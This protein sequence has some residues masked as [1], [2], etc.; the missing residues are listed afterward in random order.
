M[1][2]LHKSVSLILVLLMLL[3]CLPVFSASAADADMRYGRKKLGEAANGAAL[4]YVYDQL[5]EGC[6]A[7]IC[8]TV[9]LSHDTHKVPYQTFVDLVFPM[10]YSDYPE[11]FWLLNGGYSYTYD[12]NNMITTFTPGYVSGISNLSAAKSAFDAKVNTLLQGLSGTDYDK[13]KTLHDRLI[14]TT[15]YVSGANDQNAYGALV[16]GKAV[17]NGYVRAYQ[18]LLQKAGIPAWYVQGNSVNPSTGSSESHV[19]NLVKL[20]GQWYYT[21]VTWDDQG[22]YTF[23][24]Y[25][26]ITT[27]QLQKDHTLGALYASLVPQAT[28]TTANYYIKEDLVF[29][30]FDQARL[31]N[32]LRENKKVQFYI[33]GSVDGFVSALDTNLLSIGRQLGGTG[34]FQISYSTVIL[35]N[36]M[37]LDVVLVS[38][39]H[40]HS[41]K[42]TVP[43][44]GASCLSTGTKAYYICDCGAR[45]LDSACT[46]PLRDESQLTIPAA[47]HTPSDWKYDAVNHWTACTICGSETAN[48]RN[49]HTDSNSDYKC[50]TCNYTLPVPDESGNVNVGGGN[51]GNSSENNGG[52]ASQNPDSTTPTEGTDAGNT[53]AG[54]T[55]PTENSGNNTPTKDNTPSEG[56][57]SS[58]NTQPTTG[59][60]TPSGESDKVLS[61]KKNA[62]LIWILIGGAAA[63]IAVAVAAVVLLNK[64]QRA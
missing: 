41:V 9:N 62:Y 18:H 16:D 59:E 8:T 27:A 46:Q 20:D 7:N 40:T 39:N 26:N 13:A 35:G 24:T 19:W 21:D 5:V 57:T 63:V 2:K 38:E 52:S 58:D 4:Q 45:F 31:V 51:G 53:D 1:K 43:Q 22:A 42:T 14:D 11:Y 48:S 37:I 23:Y 30:S 10:F 49:A 54:Q 50:D 32:M 29:S 25:F 6:A 15:T 64:K 3:V 17:C 47:A 12:G 28:A 61:P 34:A 55:K 44:V 33:D 36:A 60:S 56:N